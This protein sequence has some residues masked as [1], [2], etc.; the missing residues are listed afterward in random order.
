MSDEA[1][2]KVPVDEKPS[3]LDT[4]ADTSQLS[5]NNI[6]LNTDADEIIDNN[7]SGKLI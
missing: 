4:S 6:N 7:K 5:H 2:D 1:S 3:F